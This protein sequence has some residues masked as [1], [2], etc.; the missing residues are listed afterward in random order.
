[1][2]GGTCSLG[3]LLGASLAAVVAF[4][5]GIAVDKSQEP[6]G[7]RRADGRHVGDVSQR[8]CRR[9]LSDSPI[10]DRLGECITPE[11]GGEASL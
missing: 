7:I 2:N 4:Y 10:A 11:D 6:M 8:R 9:N 5:G 1:M 3:R